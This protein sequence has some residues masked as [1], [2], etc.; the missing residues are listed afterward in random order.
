MAL[1][2]LELEMWMDQVRNGEIAFPEDD[3]DI[4]D[5]DYLLTRLNEAETVITSAI[6]DP[7]LGMRN[8]QPDCDCVLC[9]A[10]KYADR[11]KGDFGYVE[12]V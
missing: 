1:S 6:S 5:I 2:F 4:T 8:P 3:V 11:Y 10:H 9:R 12:Y 7:A